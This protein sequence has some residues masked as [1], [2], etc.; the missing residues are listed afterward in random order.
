MLVLDDMRIAQVHLIGVS[1]PSKTLLYVIGRLSRFVQENASPDSHQVGRI[2]LFLIL[3]NIRAHGSRRSSK[4]E[5]NPG[6]G[7]VGQDTLLQVAGY[8]H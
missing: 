1:H 6:T 7:Q 3:S 8:P 5:R 4:M 2:L